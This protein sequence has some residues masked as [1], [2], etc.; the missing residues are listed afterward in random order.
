MFLSLIKTRRWLGSRRATCFGWD[1]KTLGGPKGW[2]A[3]I[4][5]ARE[6]RVMAAPLQTDGPAPLQRLRAFH[7]AL[8]IH[9]LRH[10]GHFSFKHGGGAFM[11]LLW[12]ERLT[13][14]IREEG[15]KSVGEWKC[16]RKKQKCRDKAD[17]TRLECYGRRKNR[18]RDGCGG[19]WQINQTEAP[20]C[21]QRL[22]R[23]L[24]VGFK[25]INL[26]K[27]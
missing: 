23:P 1:M 18:R 10:R 7:L 15:A 5:V 22:R 26:W 19:Y 8:S 24:V 12:Q 13:E 16:K 11:M 9:T 6:R 20:A 25:R 17:D 27:I 2:N 14:R 3:G 21:I 4:E